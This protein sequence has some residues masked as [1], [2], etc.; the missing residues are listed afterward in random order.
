MHMLTNRQLVQR[1]KFYPG[2]TEYRES[3]I[4]MK[5][6]LW[7]GESTPLQN[8]F[9]NIDSKCS[10]LVHRALKRQANKFNRNYAIRREQKLANSTSDEPEN[11]SD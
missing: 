8:F 3:K 7:E 1:H 6:W 11:R 4:T 2:E 9:N 5:G 10:D